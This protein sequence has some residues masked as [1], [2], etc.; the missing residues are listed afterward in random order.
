MLKTCWSLLWFFL[1]VFT[2]LFFH[3]CSA[4][5]LVNS[6]FLV[7][8]FPG[9][10]VPVELSF[11]FFNDLEKHSVLGEGKSIRQCGKVAGK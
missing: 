8:F 7:T 1:F 5:P 10:P 9:F 11:L 6:S 3:V 4:A 2:F